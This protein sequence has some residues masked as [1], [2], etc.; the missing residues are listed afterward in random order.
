MIDF[1]EGSA[2]SYLNDTNC[3]LDEWIMAVKTLGANEWD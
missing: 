1:E 3:A 2:N